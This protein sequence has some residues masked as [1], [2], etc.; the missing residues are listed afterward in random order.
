MRGGEALI[1]L[2]QQKENGGTPGY[3]HK[4]FDVQKIDLSHTKKVVVDKAA[5]HADV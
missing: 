3:M 2:N 1:R 5:T 4:K